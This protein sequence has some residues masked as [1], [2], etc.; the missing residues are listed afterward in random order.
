M[1]ADVG[2]QPLPADPSNVTVEVA[3]VAVPRL[4]DSVLGRSMILLKHNVGQDWNVPTGGVVGR[5]MTA[6]LGA[7]VTDRSVPAGKQ[8]N[9]SVSKVAEQAAAATLPKAQEQVLRGVYP[10]TQHRPRLPRQKDA[11]SG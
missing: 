10:A 6:E 8:Q 11:R 5:K 4:S 3:D 2:T 9:A 1:E 7:E